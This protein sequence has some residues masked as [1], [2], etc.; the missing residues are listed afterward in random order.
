VQLL[1]VQ[2]GADLPNQVGGDAFERRPRLDLVVEGE[3]GQRRYR[4]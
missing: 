1:P 3:Q 2:N 4:R